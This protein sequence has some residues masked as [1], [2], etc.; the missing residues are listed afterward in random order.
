MNAQH[1]IFYVAEQKE[2]E[3]VLK[4]L[5]SYAFKERKNLSQQYALKE[6]IVGQCAYEK[7]RI[8]LTNVPDNYIKISSGL[9]EATPLNIVALPVVFEGDL[10][11]IVELAS[12]TP[13]SETTLLFLDQLSENIGIMLN[14]IAATMRTEELLK[15]SQSMSEELQNQQEELSQPGKGSTFYFTLLD[16]KQC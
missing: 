13:F 10:Q 16:E 11:A 6:G 15:E 7:Q 3:I 9:G 12:F 8:L 5:A 1:G 2:K 4:L 14:T